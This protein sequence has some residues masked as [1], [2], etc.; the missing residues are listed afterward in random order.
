MI[1]SFLWK[2]FILVQFTKVPSWL[3]IQSTDFESFKLEATIILNASFLKLNPHL[4]ATSILPCR[5]GWAPFFSLLYYA[6]LHLFSWLLQG[7]SQHKHRIAVFLEWVYH[8]VS[9]TFSEW[10]GLP[11]IYLLLINAVMTKTD[12]SVF[13]R[14]NNLSLSCFGIYYLA[15]PSSTACKRKMT[16]GTRK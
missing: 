10:L 9:F 7:F 5:N 11:S 13:S 1:R 6:I 14:F 8:L 3:W 2:P 15:M 4:I 16:S 12:Y